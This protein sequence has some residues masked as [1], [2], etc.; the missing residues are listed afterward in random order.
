MITLAFISTTNIILTWYKIKTK[1]HFSVRLCRF[2]VVIHFFTSSPQWPMTSDFILD[3]INFIYLI[4]SLFFRK[5]Q[6]FPFLMPYKGTIFITSLV[7]RG[8]WLGIEPGTSYTCCQHSTTRL[9][10][11]RYWGLNLGPPALVAST[12]PLGYRGGGTRDWTR[13]LPHL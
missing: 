12:L 13:D 8:P 7:W 4:L 3:S 10:R 5:S 11:R 9:S 6:Y 2:C 1:K